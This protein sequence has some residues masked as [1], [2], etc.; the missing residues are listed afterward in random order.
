MV[1]FMALGKRRLWV[2]RWFLIVLRSASAVGVLN[3]LLVGNP[4]GH[5]FFLVPALWTMP[6]VSRWAS[7]SQCLMDRWWELRLLIIPRWLTIVHLVP[8]VF[9]GIF[10]VLTFATWIACGTVLHLLVVAA[11]LWFLVPFPTIF[12]RR[13]QR[14]FCSVCEFLYVMMMFLFALHV[15]ISSFLISPLF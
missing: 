1:L 9:L 10:L 7:F 3:I 4:A 11:V 6:V 2:A 12:K 15:S 13:F 5:P 8:S 14:H